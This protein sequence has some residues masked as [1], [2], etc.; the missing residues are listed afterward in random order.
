MRGTI[1]IKQAAPQH[2]KP[3]GSRRQQFL[4]AAGE[5]G[6]QSAHHVAQIRVRIVPIELGRVHQADDGGGA[7]AR[8]QAAREQP[9]A[10]SDRGKRPANPS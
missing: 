1:V 8:S 5:L 4:D 9:V 6:R 7:F 2:F 10:A 3:P